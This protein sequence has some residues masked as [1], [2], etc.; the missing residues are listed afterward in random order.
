MFGVWPGWQWNTKRV[1]GMAG[2]VS[3]GP[4]YDNAHWCCGLNSNAVWIQD[5][6]AICYDCWQWLTLHAD[7]QPVACRL[8]PRGLRLQWRAHTSL[9]SRGMSIGRQ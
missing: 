1:A 9:E 8:K 4:N 3:K 5:E 2:A 7:R 6:C